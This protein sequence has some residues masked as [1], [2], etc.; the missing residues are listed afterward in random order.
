MGQQNAMERRLS[1]LEG[2][3]DIDP[4]AHLR[5]GGDPLECGPSCTE[6]SCPLRNNR[7]HELG[8]LVRALLEEFRWYQAWAEEMESLGILPEGVRKRV[9]LR[10]HKSRLED[11]LRAA[12]ENLAQLGTVHGLREGAEQRLH[13]IQSEIEQ[14]AKRLEDVP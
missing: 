9:A 12:E 13:E 5:C 10:V 1:I 8:S 11:A 2:V 14:I 4:G 3:L 6:E 7:L